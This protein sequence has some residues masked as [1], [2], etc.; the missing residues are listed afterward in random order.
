MGD[1]PAKAYAMLEA[2][3][4]DFNLN[5]IELQETHLSNIPIL[6][7]IG[8]Q[9][10]SVLAF[11][12]LRIEWDIFRNFLTRISGTY[13]EVEYHNQ[14][15]AA[16]VTSHGNYLLRATGMPVSALDHTAYL[17][18]C[19]CHDVGHSGKNNGFYVET[20]DRLALRYNDRSVL[21]QFHV[22][23]AFEMMEDFHECNIIEN[24]T[25]EERKGFRSF[26]IELILATDMA[27]HFAALT[28]LRLL[29]RNSEFRTVIQDHM[30]ADERLLIF[31]ACIKAADIG[32]TCL[33]WD[34]HYE[35]SLRLAEEFFKQGDL[36]KQLHGYVK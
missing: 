11:G 27:K 33:P 26:V 7:L 24:L 36:E 2:V 8:S 30:N 29:V 13:T 35:L 6:P 32:H 10:A 17:V 14:A 22:A 18:A 31:K 16:Q 20:G 19:I 9:L 15:H 25:R 5:L 1:I 3:G 4:Q 12:A 21:E 23:T 34:Q 28:D